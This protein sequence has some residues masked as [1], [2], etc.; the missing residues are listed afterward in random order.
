M[1]Q[2]AGCDKKSSAELF[3]GP[4]TFRNF[5]MCLHEL[6]KMQSEKLDLETRKL[7][8]SLEIL[9]ETRNDVKTMK[10]IIEVITSQYFFNINVFFILFSLN[11]I[12]RIY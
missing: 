7:R 8:R 4:S 9:D 12:F 10:D 11:L 1:Q 2:R 3:I 5:M 6:Y